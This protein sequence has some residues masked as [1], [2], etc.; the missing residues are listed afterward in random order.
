LI[1]GALGNNKAIKSIILSKFNIS[2]KDM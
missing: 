2:D 1:I